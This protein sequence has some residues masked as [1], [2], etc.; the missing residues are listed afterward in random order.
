MNVMRSMT[1]ALALATALP[2]EAAYLPD[3][4][5]A[6]AALWA[7]PAVVQARSELDAQRLRSDALK[8]GRAEWAVGLDVA[9]RRVDSLGERYAEWGASVS[10]P[11][12]LP[13]LAAADRSL[14]DA[15]VAYAG[16][17]LGEALHESGRQLLALW[18]DWL[19][20]SSQVGL[21]QEQTRIAERQLDAVN[22]RIRLGEAAR[23]ERVSAE[24]ALAQARLRLQQASSGERQARARLQ[25]AY[26]GIEVVAVDVLPAPSAPEGPVEAYV[27]AVLAHSHELLRARQ[28]AEVLRA[29]AQQLA[30]REG[31]DPN[32]GVFYRNEKGGDEQVLGLNLGLTL[33]GG[34][35]RSDRLAAEVLA[36]AAQEAA[37]RLEQRLRMEARA[38]FESARSQTASWQQAEQAPARWHRPHASPSAPTRWA[39]AAS[40]S[41]WPIAGWPWRAN[42][43]PGRRRWKRLP[44]RPGCNSTRTASGRST[45]TKLPMPCMRIH[46]TGYASAERGARPP[47]GA[48]RGSLTGS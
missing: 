21:W 38:A 1:L 45:P 20:A 32:L 41:F 36:G 27:D 37:T 4:H 14:A 8:R 47:Q 18:F 7:S 35:R 6:E 24:A 15:L 28:K 3:P 48:A 42:C 39:R 12:R 25:A 5:A 43:R 16:A 19:N 33:P 23:A 30:K 13:G 22:A 29:E 26:P 44:R 10:R 46:E 17:S 9:N 40:T 34:A 2:V 11:L 31:I